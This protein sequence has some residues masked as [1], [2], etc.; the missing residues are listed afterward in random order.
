MNRQVISIWI[1]GLMVGTGSG[2]IIARS[3]PGTES[4][5]ASAMTISEQPLAEN[6]IGKPF[7]PSHYLTDPNQFSGR[8]IQTNQSEPQ[9]TPRLFPK[10]KALP[11]QPSE[12]LM[13]KEVSSS[14]DFR[15][16]LEEI[17]PEFSEKALSDLANIRSQIE[18]EN[19][20]SPQKT[21]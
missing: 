5:Q 6:Q 10:G 21:K 4:S 2:L 14:Q 11:V 15:K 13:P 1:A 8:G 9:S 17:A 19:Q 12:S 7:E 20:G 3:V 16:D 18:N